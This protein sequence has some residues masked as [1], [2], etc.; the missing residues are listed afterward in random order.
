MTEEFL[1]IIKEEK[2]SYSGNER[3]AIMMFSL[4][5]EQVQKIFSYLET[6]EI[7]DLSQAMANLGRQTNGDYYEDYNYAI[8]TIEPGST[9]KLATLMSAIDDGYVTLDSKINASGGS[10]YFGKQKMSDSHLGIG[11]TTVREAY[12]HSSNVACAKLIWNNYSSHPEDY[13]KHLKAFQIDQPTEIDIAGEQNPRFSHPDNQFKNISSLA[14]MAI[15]YEVM[16][17]PLRTCMMYNTIANNGVMMKPYIVSS[18]KDFGVTVKEYV[19][20]IVAQNICKLSTI[21]QLKEATAAV[22]EIGTGKALKNDVYTICGKTGTAQVAD[23]GITYKDRVYHGSFVGFFPKE[24][25]MY[26]IC[27]VIRTKK[28]ANNYYGGQIALPVFK[29]VADRLYANNIKEHSSIEN[30]NKILFTVNY[31]N[32]M[33]NTQLKT[34]NKSL[35]IYKNLPTT[36][37]NWLGNVKVD[38]TGTTTYNDL[39]MQNNIVPNISGMSLRNAIQLLENLGLK[40]NVNGHGKINNQSI[41]P[42]TAFTK[43]ET[44]IIQLS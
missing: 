14:W 4:P 21:Q 42:G 11:E 28:G 13:L 41:A 3:A 32:N 31:T 29:E 9:F 23:K 44:I 39:L 22:V 40:V 2:I 25:P 30:N 18:I 33:E 36:S 35:N 17:S 38:S 37:S 27:V 8:R 5:D 19:P 7:K 26:T 6:E 20:T 15:G 16:I 43:G 12:A 10:F 24:N 1:N 34:L